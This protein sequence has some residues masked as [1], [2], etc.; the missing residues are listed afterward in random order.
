[1]SDDLT[2]PTAE[3][4]P[5]PEVIDHIEDIFLLQPDVP[6]ERPPSPGFQINQYG[7]SGEH[8]IVRGPSSSTHIE[9]PLER[10][11]AQDDYVPNAYDDQNTNENFLRLRSLRANALRIRSLLR[12]KRKLLRDKQ[13][14]KVATDEAFMRYVREHA[15]A[16]EFNT[17]STKSDRLDELF[18]AM[19]E[20]RDMYGPLQDEYDE[21]EETLDDTEFEMAMI[22][23]RIHKETT[24]SNLETPLQDRPKDPLGRAST[25][26]PSS[27]MDF[28]SDSTEDY[29]P[30]HAQYLSRLGDLDLAKERLQNM[31]QE[32]QALHSSKET[33]LNVGLDLHESLQ[34]ILTELPRQIAASRDEIVEIERDVERLYSTCLAAGIDVDN[35]GDGNEPFTAK[36]KE[37]MEVNNAAKII[38]EAGDI[39]QEVLPLTST[40]TQHCQSTFPLLLPRTEDEEAKLSSLTPKFDES[41]KGGQI[42]HWLLNELHTSRLQISLLYRITDE[43]F[44]HCNLDLNIQRWQVEVLQFWAKDETNK[45]TIPIDAYVHSSTVPSHPSVQQQGRP[46]AKSIGPSSKFLICP[47]QLL[48]RRSAPGVLQY[49]GAMKGN[50]VLEKIRF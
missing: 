50:E 13:S 27:F 49:I 48:S 41:N 6:T 2:Q 9:G 5:F 47:P 21:V 10:Y 22:E 16:S 11:L 8:H 26:A 3:L 28:G 15:S 19:Q 23:G 35:L 14:A 40:S 4:E 12:T 45:S 34:A 20:T 29:H 38:G 24:I 37:E 44:L 1:M 25:H 39:L 32:M 7:A 33:R 17:S 36:D 43:I 46:L 31:R 30:L 42:N 18:N